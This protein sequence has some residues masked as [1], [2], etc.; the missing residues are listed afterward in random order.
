VFFIVAH[1]EKEKTGAV[2]TNNSAR[3]ETL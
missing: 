1:R 2:F 3:A